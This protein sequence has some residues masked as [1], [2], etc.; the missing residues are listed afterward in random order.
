[1]WDTQHAILFSQPLNIH[2]AE[3]KF[4]MPWD[5]SLWEADTSEEWRSL[6]TTLPAPPLFLS[7]LKSYVTPDIDARP[8]NINGLSRLLA[9]HGLLSISQSLA[10]LPESSLQSVQGRLGKDPWQNRIEKAYTTWH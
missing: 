10:H 9:L 6:Q 5:T 7:V 8:S 2:P 3:L 4:S 1:M